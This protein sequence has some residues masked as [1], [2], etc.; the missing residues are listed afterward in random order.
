MQRTLFVLQGTGPSST[1]SDRSQ[2]PTANLNTKTRPKFREFPVCFIR[3]LSG[4]TGSCMTRYNNYYAGIVFVARIMYI[5]TITHGYYAR[6]PVFL[7]MPKL[8]SVVCSKRPYILVDRP[9][10][11]A[12]DEVHHVLAVLID[13]T[14]VG[15]VVVQGVDCTAL[16]VAVI[17]VAMQGGGEGITGRWIQAGEDLKF[18]S[19]VSCCPLGDEVVSLTPKPSVQSPTFHGCRGT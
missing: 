14:V 6:L 19:C 9:I 2:F 5:I 12:L 7:P 1:R 10:Q 3:R 4:A 13:V 15:C 11:A 17:A 18:S 8:I 16:V